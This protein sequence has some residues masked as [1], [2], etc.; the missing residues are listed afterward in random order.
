MATDVAVLHT[1]M[2][3]SCSPIVVLHQLHSDAMI[4]SP[5]LLNLC[6]ILFFYSLLCRHLLVL[7]ISLHR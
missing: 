3:L 2:A 5:F 1:A 7:H 6:I 4:D